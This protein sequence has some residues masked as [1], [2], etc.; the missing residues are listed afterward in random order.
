MKFGAPVRGDV[1][2]GVTSAIV[3][4]PMALAFGVASGLGPVAGIY[5]AVRG[6][7]LCRRV[8]WHAFADLRSHR[9]DDGRDGGHRHPLRRQ[10]GD[11]LHHRHAGRPAANRAGSPPDRHLRE[12][13]ALFGDFGLHD[14]DRRDHHGPAGPALPRRQ[15]GSGRTSGPDR[16]L[17]GRGSPLPACTI[18]P[19]G[20][21]PW[22]SASCGLAAWAGSCP[23][24]WS[25][26]RA[27][28]CVALFWLTEV[29]TIR[30]DSRGPA[31]VPDAAA[32]V[33][34]RS[35]ASWNRR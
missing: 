21:S 18:S 10:P 5:G 34:A 29:G 25:P 22:R 2:G 15:P 27:G 19:S 13:H 32:G 17:A 16:G 3:M 14:R 4:L 8:R 24:R 31:C 20:P 7:I 12:L 23:R 30:R 6:G 35:G 11:R 26:W 1:F 9:A 33:G 28:T